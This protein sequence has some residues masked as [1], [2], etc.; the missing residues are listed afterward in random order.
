M[1]GKK[2]AL[3]LTLVLATGQL[4]TP[5]CQLAFAE[6]AGSARPAPQTLAFN[7]ILEESF[8]NSLSRLLVLAALSLDNKL[9]ESD[10]AEVLWNKTQQT[11]AANRGQ[12]LSPEKA[13]VLTL[14]SAR[15][16]QYYLSR[17]VEDR[18]QPAAQW[19]ET[20][21][22]VGAESSKKA[23]VKAKFT[24]FQNLAHFFNSE[25][26][27]GF[28]EFTA[29]RPQLQADKALAANTD[30][31]SAYSLALSPSSAASA[32][33]FLNQAGPQLGVYGKIVQKLLEASMDIGLD[34]EGKLSGSIKPSYETK[35]AAATR[36][37]KSLPAASQTQVLNSAI[38]IW[39]KVQGAKEGAAPAYLVE[40]FKG[41][42][43]AAALREREALRLIKGQK[44]SEARVIYKQIAEGL[45]D[46]SLTIDHRLW[47]I[48]VLIYQKSGQIAELEKSYL[49]LK[50]RYRGEAKTKG[51]PAANLWQ[52][53]SETYR[54]VLDQ[55]LGQAQQPQAPLAF[56][57]LTAQTVLSFTKIEGDSPAVLP[58]KLRLAQLYRSLNQF[59][60]ATDL[61]LELAIR[62]PSPKLYMAAIEA[63][64]Q[65][66]KWPQ[67]PPF[68]AVPAGPDEERQRLYSIF[69]KAAKVNKSGDEWFALAHMGLLLRSLQKDKAMEDLWR[70]ALARAAATQ[71]LALEAGGLL[72]ANAYTAKR[73]QDVIDLSHLFSQRRLPITQKGKALAFA[74]WLGDALFSGGNADLQSKNYPRAVKNLEEFIQSYE[75]DPRVPAAL[76]SSAFAYVGMNKYTP[77][78]NAC[79]S[80]AEKFPAYPPRARLLL[81]AGEW[82][83]LEKNNI[84]FA[85][86][87]YGKYLGDYKNEAN[88]PQIRVQLAEIYL[89]RR[90]YGWASRLYREQSQAPGVS[91]DQQLQ[92]AIKVMD[93]EER[94]GELK[95]AS[96]GASR[97]LQLASPDDP[98]SIRAIAFQARYVAQSKDL[99]GMADIE[100]RILPL[101]SR[102]K[103]ALEALG[104][105]RFRRA[106]LTTQG[107]FNEESNLQ[108]RDPEATVKK[109]ADRF[110][111][112][113]QPYLKVCQMGVNTMCAPAYWRLTA[114]ATQALEAVEKVEIAD[115]LGQSRVNSFKVFK[116]LQL[117]KIISSRKEM[118]EQA[119]RL[120]QQGTTTEAWKEE[121]SK[122]AFLD[123]QA[124]LAH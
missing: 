44:Y 58:Y 60:E 119:L 22:K 117:N 106:E 87:F 74:P 55:M 104:Q 101:V 65:L 64:S 36:L 56:K 90:L 31:F 32:L 46:L 99:K 2:A 63:Q 94:Y 29:L 19:L 35:L 49:D 7:P 51:S 66:A 88:I 83:M 9:L 72:L 98:A 77:A 16:L 54:G 91:K 30:L 69:E 75:A 116:Q 20:Y 97:I 115:T 121:I 34:G 59:R 85:I 12:E 18:I 95:D 15:L 38:Y 47:E 113:K 61:F 118:R 122:A 50:S 33:T 82:A 111:V 110:D 13:K 81:Q 23:A 112:E 11:I 37:A 86:Y 62:E 107:I 67:Q 84:E 27:Q 45:S 1:F 78:L 76:H 57:K 92:A 41:Q 6:E 93:I 71:K 5:V 89:K 68:E 79:R 108:I 39:L 40:G 70:P 96:L 43:P 102:S 105:L 10:E 25:G 8:P 48:D 124:N 120:V 123:D 109:Y 26:R 52:A 103:E 21:A 4:P 114:V 73:W 17:N 14:Q 42:R 53:V 80:I 3:T 28:S 100:A 24:Y